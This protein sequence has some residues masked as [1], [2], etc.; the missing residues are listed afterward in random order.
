MPPTWESF[1]AERLPV[2]R[3]T[4]AHS[5]ARVLSLTDPV[6]V[7]GRN[8]PSD[9][10]AETRKIA[11]GLG[12]ATLVTSVEELT[13][14]IERGDLGL[15][16]LACHQEDPGEDRDGGVAMQDGVFRPVTL[17]RAAARRSLRERCP[18]VFFNACRSVHGGS[19][20]TLM[21]GWANE[22][23]RA[24]AGAFV[25]STWAVRSD[26]AHRYAQR[27]YAE[28]RGGVPLAAASFA[29]RNELLDDPA[30]PTRLAYA[31]YGDPRATALDA[32]EATV[33]D[34]GQS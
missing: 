25:G 12:T 15:L 22:F 26:S 19:Y 27:F 24:G 18:L 31:V 1:A 8:P 21:G 5:L 34:G 4:A 28:L 9:A 20:D 17:G 7:V 10:L 6:F 33:L 14:R 11:G 29:A 32:G 2:L 16:H 3:Q 30:D 23:V 13:R